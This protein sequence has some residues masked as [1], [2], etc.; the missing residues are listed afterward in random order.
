VAVED[1][2][3]PTGLIGSV[4]RAFKVLEVVAREGAG[5]TA[6]AVARRTG[7][8][9]STTYH[10]LNTLVHEGYLVRLANARGFGLGYKIPDLH[11]QLCTE[12]DVV[13]SV[14]DVLRD[15]HNQASAPTYFTVFRDSE[16]VVAEVADSPRFP[17]AE[18]L[19]LGFHE[20]SHATAFG[21]L[22]LSAMP[23]R[24]LRDYLTG[25]GLPRLTSRTITRR[26]DLDTELEHIRASG[27]ALEVEEFKPELACLAAPVRNSAGVVTG[28]VA[29]SVPAAEFSRRRWELERVIKRGAAKVTRLLV[30]ATEP[31]PDL[32]VEIRP[33]IRDTSGSWHP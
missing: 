8:K 7:F 25:A 30:S 20:A 19:D 5:I 13:P 32:P 11:Y 18:P 21:K 22:L 27:V 16:L 31:H 15:L 23:P 6:K 17:R 2:R 9:L 28:A 1:Q 12:L 29:T 33:D 26:E 3:S 10:L 14:Y 24:E 4:Q